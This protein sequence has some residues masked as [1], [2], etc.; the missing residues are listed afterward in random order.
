MILLPK[1][2]KA[3][4]KFLSEDSYCPWPQFGYEEVLYEIH[5]L[6]HFNLV[7][8]ASIADGQNIDRFKSNA[9]AQTREDINKL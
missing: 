2:I 1:P 3:K 5:N 4:H 7:V 6:I 9:Q 8:Q